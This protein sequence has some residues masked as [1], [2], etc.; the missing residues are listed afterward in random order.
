MNEDRDWI[1]FYYVKPT[2]ELFVTEVTKYFE[3]GE[4]VQGGNNWTSL[5]FFAKI[6]ADNSQSIRPWFNDLAVLESP[7]LE[8]LLQAASLSCDESVGD[9]LEENGYARENFSTQSILNYDVDSGETL[10]MLWGYFFA[11]G[12]LEPIRRIISALNFADDYGAAE[13]HAD[14]KKT[15]EITEA[16]MRDAV[17]QAATWSLE[18][19]CLEHPLVLQHCEE[20][21]NTEL[22]NN[23]MLYL[24]ILLSKIKPESY[25]VD[26]GDEG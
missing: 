9:Y 14:S 5:G 18:A 3:S 21:I 7:K 6:I 11:S 24:A 20:I 10:D 22:S 8:L 17:F 15:T 13:E 16:I 19:N 12:E 25:S 23:E 2:P 4:I 1:T 26:F